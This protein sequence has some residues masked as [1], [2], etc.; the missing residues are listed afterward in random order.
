[1][2]DPRSGRLSDVRL[3]RREAADT[4]RG[5]RSAA[6][7]R[8]C[9]RSRGWTSTPCSSRP[10]DPVDILASFLDWAD[11]RNVLGGSRDTAQAAPRRAALCRR[12]C[13]DHPPRP[14]PRRRSSGS[15]RPRGAI[16]PDRNP[17]DVRPARGSFR[18]HAQGLVDVTVDRRRVEPESVRVRPQFSPW[19]VVASPER[20]RR[21]TQ[22]TS[23][24]RTTY[25]LRC[26]I[27]PCVPQRGTSSA[28]VRS[29]PRR[30]HDDAGSEADVRPHSLA[31]ARHPLED[32][33]GRLRQPG[34][35]YDPV[36]SRRARRCPQSPI[37]SHPRDCG[38]ACSSSARLLTLTA[39][40]LA[41]TS[42]PTRAPRARAGARAGAGAAAAARARARPPRRTRCR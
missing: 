40:V 29:R 2:R 21:D 15:D 25:V 24:I 34:C 13:R 10:S 41:C 4:A 6:E 39:V 3:T 36:A 16:R 7:H 22:S 28:R 26:V 33:L 19:S 14:R 12:R 20:V 8:C 27:S 35:G 17:V 23:F 1:M 18:R 30:L 42:I 37:G 32:R 38:S 9:R 11:M 5:E 31:G